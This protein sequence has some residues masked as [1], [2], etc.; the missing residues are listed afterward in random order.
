VHVKITHDAIAAHAARLGEMHRSAFPVVM[1]QTLNKAAF[2]VKQNTMPEESDVFIHRK[3]TFFQANSKVVPAV[4]FDMNS[5]RATVGFIPKPD[6]KDTSVSDLEEQEEGGEI[7][8]RAFIPLAT[9]RVNNSWYGNVR[10]SGRWRAVQNKI[11]DSRD[12]KATNPAGQFKS[13]AKWGGAGS[14]VIGSTENSKGN[15]MVWRIDA[16]GKTIR[17]RAMFALKAG[18]TV[19]PEATHFMRRA[20]LRSGRNLEKYFRELAEAKLKTMK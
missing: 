5:M 9:N 14:L 7:H 10:A 16:V 11:I 2:D 15:R 1:R 3:K 4:G 6:A 20:S 12:S 17:K 19:Q 8:G 13:T 18:R